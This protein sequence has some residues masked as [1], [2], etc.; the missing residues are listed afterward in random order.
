MLTRLPVSLGIDESDCTKGTHEVYKLYFEIP[1]IEQA[2]DYYKK[3]S[4]QFLADNS[5]VEYMKKVSLYQEQFMSFAD[6]EIRPMHD[7]KKRRAT[8]PSTSY[9]RS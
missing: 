6:C 1:F 4:Q 5:V 3:E 7:S 8:F 9:Q 2:K